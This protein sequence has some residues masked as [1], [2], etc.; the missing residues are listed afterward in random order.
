MSTSSP[1]SRQPA[2]TYSLTDKVLSA[3]IYHCTLLADGVVVAH[4]RLLITK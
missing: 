1:S 2:R 4:E 3:G